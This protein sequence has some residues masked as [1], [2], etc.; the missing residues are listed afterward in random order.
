M[1]HKRSTGVAGAHDIRG[2]GEDMA[3]LACRPT[4]GPNDAGWGS[5]V[6]QAMGWDC[7]NYWASSGVWIFATA[8]KEYGRINLNYVNI[9]KD[10]AS[11]QDISILSML[12]I[13]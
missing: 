3:W 13:G 8:S 7:G 12:N 11:V 6:R 10:Y 2:G 1:R 5:A 9:S 4:S